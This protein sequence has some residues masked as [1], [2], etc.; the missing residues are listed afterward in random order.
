MAGRTTRSSSRLGIT[1]PC[2]GKPF[3]VSKRKN[4]KVFTE[5]EKKEIAKYEIK[6]GQFKYRLRSVKDILKNLD[7]DKSSE[8]GSARRRGRKSKLLAS[9]RRSIAESVMLKNFQKDAQFNKEQEEQKS[10][11]NQ[12]AEDTLEAKVEQEE[13]QIHIEEKNESSQGAEEITEMVSEIEQSEMNDNEVPLV[14]DTETRQTTMEDENQLKEPGI[15]NL[16]VKARVKPVNETEEEAAERIK[17]EM[18]LRVETLERIKELKKEQEEWVALYGSYQS[19]LAEVESDQTGELS[20][21]VKHSLLSDEQ[22][23]FMEAKMD[24]KD[25]IDRLK[26]YQLD[27]IACAR[28]VQDFT[29]KMSEFKKS[30]SDYLT[31]LPSIVSPTKEGCSRTPRTLITNILGRAKDIASKSDQSF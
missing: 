11:S 15:K 8:E 19:R 6:A 14:Q 23:Q 4:V 10:P 24:P 25:F 2:V 12:Q 16:R 9:K 18:R 5:N 27:Y 28:Y 7:N 1:S 20:P 26:Q 31:S 22:R 3:K 17:A 29:E 21:D 30:V 13:N